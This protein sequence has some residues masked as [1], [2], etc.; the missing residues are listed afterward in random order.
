MRARLTG[1]QEK[2][3]F[4]LLPDIINIVLLNFDDKEKVRELREFTDSSPYGSLMQTFGWAQVKEGWQHHCF[5]TEENGRVTAAVS[6]LS[7]AD[8]DIGGRFFYAPRGPV[9]DLSDTA[10]VCALLGEISDFARSRNGFLFRMDPE[11]PENPEI[12]ELY[13][14]CG[15]TFRKDHGSTSQPL[16]SLVM[17]FSESGFANAEEILASLSTNTRKTVR[18]SYRL[19]ISNRVGDRGDLPEFYRILEIMNKYHGIT[20]R[21]YDYFER[22]YDAFPGNVR[23]SFSMYEGEAVATSMLVTHGN[24]A[25]SMYGADTHEYNLGQS[26]QINFEELKYTFEHGYR[27]YDMGGIFSTDEEN[28]GLYRF[29]RKFTGDG[30]VNWIGN[31]DIPLDEEKYALF[32]R[33][34]KARAH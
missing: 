20:Y 15:Y 11:I 6:V 2:I 14:S 25:F 9:C 18:R 21:P 27:Y 28:D 3:P 7:I 4:P 32:I 5:Y 1:K 13:R 17:D 30:V 23:L 16:Q 10:S 12:E 31:L 29:K 34:S 19:G 8:K 22:L 26:Y 24:R 33:R